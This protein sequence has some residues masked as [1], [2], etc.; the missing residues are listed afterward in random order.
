LARIREGSVE[1][2]AEGIPAPLVVVFVV[3]VTAV[4]ALS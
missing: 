2:A 4:I 1:V 3:T